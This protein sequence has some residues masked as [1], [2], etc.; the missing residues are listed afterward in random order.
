MF[1]KPFVNLFETKNNKYVYDVNSNDIVCIN[2]TTYDLLHLLQSGLPFDECKEILIN[3]YTL[4]DIE[5]AVAFINRCQE[6]GMLF[7][8]KHPCH[9]EYMSCKKHRQELYDKYLSHGILEI[10]QQCNLECKYCCY[11]EFYPGNRQNS[12]RHMSW[13]VAKKALDLMIKHG[14]RI[15][16]PFIHDMESTRD[17]SVGFYGGEPFLNF[18]MMNQC[19]EYVKE[20]IDADRKALFTLTTNA[21][22]LTQEHIQWLVDNQ[23]SSVISLDGP[24]SNH[25]RFRVDHTG[26]GTHD[27]VMKNVRQILK[28]T[29]R[30]KTEYHFSFNCVLCGDIDL[31]DVLDYFC[32]MEDLFT[33]PYCKVSVNIQAVNGGTHYYNKCYPDEQL[34]NV[35]GFDKLKDEYN[36]A[37]LTNQ[38]R[39]SKISVRLRILDSFMR[40]QLYFKV[41]GRTR[42]QYSDEFELRDKYFPGS[43]CPM[44]SRRTYFDVDGNILPCERVSS[45]ES[46]FIIGNVNDGID[47][48]CVKQMIDE[49]TDL[50]K[51]D[52]KKCWCLRMCS[53][54]CLEGVIENHV[55]VKKLKQ[56]RCALLRNQRQS[57]MIEMMTLLEQNPNAL[58]HY[59][60]VIST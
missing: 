48:N 18:E 25:D 53:V 57:E 39:N 24:K 16:S 45:K 26:N 23:V 51:E 3:S 11:S 12:N 59:N 8:Q 55:P 52:C 32:M 9:I 27:L 17:V 20:N 31:G 56:K 14:G 10:T 28:Y 29:E 13:D 47:V 60:Q 19:V 42:Y 49:F 2:E 34:S 7:S 35:T 44:G 37:C 43:I 36:E 38:Y 41:H 50:T 1:E 6:S 15:R 46:Y 58:D 21:T 4:N 40:D 54:G 30:K 5:I 22:M 33:H